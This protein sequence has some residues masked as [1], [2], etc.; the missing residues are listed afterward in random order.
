MVSKD[1]ETLQKKLENM[2]WIRTEIDMDN[3]SV[4]F[5]KFFEDGILAKNETGS[6]GLIKVILFFK[7]SWQPN[8]CKNGSYNK[9]FHSIYFSDGG[10]FN[11]R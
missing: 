10:W 11:S 6:F 9:K 3:F 4:T 1:R 8:R 2:G 5:I 7:N